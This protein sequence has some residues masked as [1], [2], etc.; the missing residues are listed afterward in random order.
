M[1]ITVCSPGVQK[2][3]GRGQVCLDM[4]TVFGRHQGGKTLK[5]P[6]AACGMDSPCNSSWRAA[7]RE[8]DLEKFMETGW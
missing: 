5:V 4:L 7:A 2:V 1:N 3:F 6:T 8:M